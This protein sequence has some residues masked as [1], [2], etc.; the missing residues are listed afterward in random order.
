MTLM[1]LNRPAHDGGQ[2]FESSS[3]RARATEKA[4]RGGFSR[5]EI[6]NLLQELGLRLNTMPEADLERLRQLLVVHR[7]L[8]S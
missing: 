3:Q 4:E 6:R 5:D 1:D 7:F 8:P 2:P